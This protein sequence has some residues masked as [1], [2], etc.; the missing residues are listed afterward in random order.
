MVFCERWQM[1]K[2]VATTCALKGSDWDF[3][4]FLKY[5]KIYQE[6]SLWQATTHVIIASLCQL[7]SG[8]LASGSLAK[9]LQ[10]TEWHYQERGRIKSFR[11]IIL[12]VCPH[13]HYFIYFYFLIMVYFNFFYGFWGFLRV[14]CISR[15]NKEFSFIPEYIWK[16]DEI[17]LKPQPLV[18]LSRPGLMFNLS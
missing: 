5:R 12:I 15:L 18:T 17:Y 14:W 2:Q 6:F 13:S 4:T 8:S 1:Y 9:V 10:R 7:A 16:S 3:N 11:I